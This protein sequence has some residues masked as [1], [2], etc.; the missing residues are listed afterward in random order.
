MATS[1]QGV[2]DLTVFKGDDEEFNFRMT[3]DGVATDLTGTVMLFECTIA[4]LTR[5]ATIPTPATGEFTVT[6][7][8]ADTV[9]LTETVVEYEVVRY[10]SGLG[11]TRV[12]IF[13]GQLCLENER[14]K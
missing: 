3:S 1:N 14:V 13:G 2:Y 8:A 4:S 6:L 5:Q 10:P 9:D 12:T 11:G 7:P